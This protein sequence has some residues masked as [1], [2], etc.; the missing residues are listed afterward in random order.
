M[1]SGNNE[2][3]SVFVMWGV[4]PA[5]IQN[6]WSHMIESSVTAR[7]MH[8]YQNNKTYYKTY[9]NDCAAVGH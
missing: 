6:T 5:A 3:L 7:V 9:S 8:A 1:V 2:S 4:K